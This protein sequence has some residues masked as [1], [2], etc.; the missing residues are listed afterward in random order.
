M[1]QRENSEQEGLPPIST[2][3]ASAPLVSMFLLLLVGVN[4]LDLE[5][6][7]VLLI[8]TLLGAALVAGLSA[9]RRG[10]GWDA[11]QR[12]TGEKLAAVLPA[13][14]ILLCIGLMIGS[15]VLSGT[16]PLLVYYGVRLIHPDYVVLT[17]FLATSVMSLCTGTSWGSAGTIGV[18]LMGMALAL[19][20]PLGAAAGAVVSGAYLGDKLSP[21]SDMTNI[22]AIGAGADL[23][24]HIRNMLYTALPSALLACLVYAFFGGR[25]DTAVH[26]GMPPAASRLLMELDHCF[27]L[28]P[29]LLIPPILVI[30]GVVLRQA[31]AL[32]LALSSLSA[33]LLGVLWQGFTVQQALAAGISGFRIDMLSSVGFNPAEA[34]PLL[35]TLLDRGGMYSMSNTLLL[36]IAAFLLAAA[37][38]L[39][40][41]LDKLVGGL[42]AAV[43]STLG[44]VAASMASGTLL[45]ALTSHGGVT[46][47]IVGELFQKPYREY[48]LA[49]ENLSRALED[50]V[51]IVE[52]VLPWTVSAVFMATTLGVPTLSYLPWAIFCLGGPF[53]SLVYGA[54]YDRTGFG[55]KSL[56]IQNPK[57]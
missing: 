12:V 42:L 45:I 32:T 50:S 14:L 25:G 54:T 36:I 19:N 21:L 28:H 1:I 49:P 18:A 46:A 4:L 30:S 13:V 24:R 51:T 57:S 20:I 7:P 3:E 56:E 35:Q 39:S 15:W 34:S 27:V 31:P 55:L 41:A 26:A 38:E 48:R 10:Q 53:F 40:G 33:L 23:Y 9:V 29:L 16:I 22:C 52:P 17:A 2:L 6:G 5:L 44:L 47:L 37:M 11:I 8:W 43:H